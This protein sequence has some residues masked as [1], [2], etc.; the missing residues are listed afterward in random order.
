LV[1]EALAN[2]R[3]DMLIDLHED[4][5]GEGFYLYEH[6]RGGAPVGPH[7]IARVR[8]AGFPIQAGAHIEGRALHDGCVEPGNEVP[9][10]TNGYFSIFAF[11]KYA[12]RTIVPETP[13]AAPLGTRVAMHLAAIEAA[14]ES[15]RNLR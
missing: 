10:A 1:R 8:A 9:S 4:T 7:V 11:D 6:V 5:D 14:T 3:F 12:D 13:A 2:Q 15:L